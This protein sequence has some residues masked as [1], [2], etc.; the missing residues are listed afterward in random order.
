M[1]VALLMC[2][3]NCIQHLTRQQQPTD[4][5]SHFSL[6]ASLFHRMEIFSSFTVLLP[7]LSSTGFLIPTSAR[8]YSNN[9]FFRINHNNS[10]SIPF[11]L[12]PFQNYYLNVIMTKS[13]RGDKEQLSDNSLIPFLRIRDEE[14]QG[15]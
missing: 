15:K 3:F 2:F 7:S 5:S 1:C 9:I 12:Y 11:P 14:S 8:N 4:S 10:V 13:V 6:F